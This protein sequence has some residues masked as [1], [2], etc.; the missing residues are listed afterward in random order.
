VSVDEAAFMATRRDN[1]GSKLELWRIAWPMMVMEVSGLLMLFVD[2]AFVGHRSTIEL[3]AVAV[4]G[5]I[6]WV[7]IDAFAILT[8]TGAI[9][10][11]H[12]DGAA[13]PRDAGRV[14]WQMIWISLAS[15][16]VFVA[17]AATAP[18]LFGGT[19]GADAMIDYFQWLL[20]LAPLHALRGALAGVFIGR[21]RTRILIAAGV[22]GNVVNLGLDALLIPGT[23]GLPALGVAGAAI[24]TG[25]GAAAQVLLL[26]VGLLRQAAVFDLGHPSFDPAL[27]RSCLR[28]AG[29][30]A[31]LVFVE[32]LGYG[33]F[34]RIYADAAPHDV[35]F[36]TTAQSLLIPFLFVY[37]GIAGATSSVVASQH[38]AGDRLLARHTLRAA[39]GIATTAGVVAAMAL[40]LLGPTLLSALDVSSEKLG[41][42]GPAVLFVLVGCKITSAAISGAIHGTLA[43][44]GRT[45]SLLVVGALA[46]S[47]FLVVPA[48][49]ITLLG[50]PGWVAVASWVIRDL[51]F[52]AIA[53][54]FVSS[55]LRADAA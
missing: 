8:E 37:I 25:C 4:A 55:A 10:I 1:S 39:L 40:V 52:C 43:G 41:S 30:A 47:L 50:L 14:A 34:H 7:F 18:L 42:P 6:A 46:T 5:T 28:I 23:A 24:A 27:L 33:I 15:V 44:T 21:G 20:W 29:P 12:F 49:V 31:A 22:L 48:L 3:N 9:P 36:T 54:R 13:R 19:I 35:T 17:L 53:S 38:G 26:A 45:A 16:V 51:A 11:A 2:R 32:M